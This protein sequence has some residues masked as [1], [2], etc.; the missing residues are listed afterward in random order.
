M[1]GKSVSFCLG[2]KQKIPASFVVNRIP[3]DTV[4]IDIR[5]SS[6]HQQSLVAA[7]A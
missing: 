1:A 2:A 6:P 3:D 4:R 5:K 7:A